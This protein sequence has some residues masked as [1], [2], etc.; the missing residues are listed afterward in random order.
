[1]SIMESRYDE[2]DGEYDGEYDEYDQLHEKVTGT[3]RQDFV[4][5]DSIYQM[6]VRSQK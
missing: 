5:S 2:Y 4:L 6:E 1:M 3:V